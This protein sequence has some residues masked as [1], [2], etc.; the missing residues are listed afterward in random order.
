MGYLSVVEQLIDKSIKLLKLEGSSQ[1]S[2]ELYKLVIEQAY[3]NSE[4]LVSF[5]E[6]SSELQE[7]TNSNLVKKSF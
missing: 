7:L 2:K 4:D 3:K 5:L 1:Q 6:A